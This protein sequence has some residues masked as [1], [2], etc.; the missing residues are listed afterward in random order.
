[1]AETYAVLGQAAPSATTETVLL[2]VPAATQVVTSTLAI[3]NL[4]GTAAHADLNVRP[5][6][7]AV[8][9]AHAN[10]RNATVD[11][12]S[13]VWLTVGITLAAGDVISVRSDTADALAF[14]LYGTSIA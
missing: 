8:T 10:L 12:Y 4:T 7:A 2:T 9:N 1:M 14:S 5:G 11:A 3:T 13:T 6:G